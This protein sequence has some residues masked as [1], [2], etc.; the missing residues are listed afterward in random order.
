MM[1][2]P[3]SSREKRKRH[4]TMKDVAELAGVS[5]TT[6][7]F[8]I[9][10]VEGPSISEETRHRVWEAV[11]RLRYR[12]NAAAKM[13]RTSSS[14]SIGFVTDVLA[15]S[16]FAGDMIRGAQDGAW[17]RGHLMIIVNTGGDPV[18]ERAAIEELLERRVNGVI[19]A[20]MAHHEVAPP[21][22]LREVPA[23]LLDCYSS[24]DGF[25]SVRP[26][27]VG[28]GFSATD[29]LVQAGHRRI[30]FI[31][32]GPDQVKLASEGRLEGYWRALNQ[33]DVAFDANLVRNGN[34][35][36]DD[37]YRLARELLTLADPPTALFC[38]TDRMAM[39]AYDAARDL[40][41]CIPDDISIVGFDDQRLLS[42]YL[43]PALSTVALPF[44]EMGRMAAAQL[45]STHDSDEDFEPTD[46]LVEC[47][48]VGRQ[49]T[50][51][52]RQQ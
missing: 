9:N 50:A 47:S 41:K 4:A 46:H 5:Q 10:H 16:P 23:V 42:M 28:G 44:Y 32:I 3:R 20:S 11:R 1:D 8:V 18:I 27:E 17:D 31:N 2:G 12:P 33:A 21:E 25:A 34:A 40:G 29:A 6:V 51:P 49:S 22:N 37:G 13:L 30:G 38:G 24:E 52:P 15:S 19:Y 14:R 48:F 39:G 26:D 7:S 36:A 45:C 43:R 35:N